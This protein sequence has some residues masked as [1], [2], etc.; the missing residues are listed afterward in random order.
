[1]SAIK[2]QIL[3]IPDDGALL[4]GRHSN[5]SSTRFSDVVQQAVVYSSEDEGIAA[6]GDGTA[7]TPDHDDIDKGLLV[8]YDGHILAD[9][10]GRLR[11]PK[12]KRD[13]ISLHR[14]LKSCCQYL[15][16]YIVDDVTVESSTESPSSWTTTSFCE[17]TSESEAEDTPP[18]RRPRSA[19]KN[20]EGGK[21]ADQYH[22]MR[23]AELR[24][25]LAER[26]LPTHGVKADLIYRLRKSD[27]EPSALVDQEP[28]EGDEN[29]DRPQVTEQAPAD[30]APCPSE[31]LG[32]VPS[33]PVS[34]ANSDT[35]SA[36][37]GETTMLGSLL[38]FGSRLF[39]LSTGGI[40]ESSED[41]RRKRFRIA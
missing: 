28:D 9:G 34:P 3:H 29:N 22:N 5:G 8:S 24:K 33:A 13:C 18:R 14:T 23:V 6:R 17:P 25:V 2:R 30:G 1:M 26:G 39:R 7:R 32:R 19:K 11:P 21:E 36:R 15:R 27:E 16:K 20:L 12:T 35:E 31:A 38:D 10:T 40:S 37:G 41:R 4:L